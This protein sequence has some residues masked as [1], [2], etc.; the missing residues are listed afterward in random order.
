MVGETHMASN[1]EIKAKII[2]KFVCDD[3]VGSR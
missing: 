3:Y 1:E 2:R